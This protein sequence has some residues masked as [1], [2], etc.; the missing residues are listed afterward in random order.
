M[1]KDKGLALQLRRQDRSYR[2]ISRSLDVPKSTLATWFKSDRL[3]QKTKRLL[4]KRAIEKS[5]QRIKQLVAVN[6]V[7][8]EKWR[9]EAREEA[10]KTFALLSKSPLFVSGVML[11]WAEGD[12]KIRNPFRLTNTDPRMVALYVRFLVE[13]LNIP[14]ET[15]RPT[16]ILYPDLEE[17][18]CMRFWSKI[19]GVPK[20][21]FYKTQFIKGRHP[22]KRLSNGICTITCGNRQS[23]EK[24]LVWIDLLSKK[25][26]Q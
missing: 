14:E 15:I 22:T 10:R 12:S 26:L 7:R 9:E 13:S 17:V 25:L 6:K 24:I 19:I 4:A 11:Y 3:S 23:K 2:E 1:R 20:S 5:R 8:W 16:L 18:S 21:Q